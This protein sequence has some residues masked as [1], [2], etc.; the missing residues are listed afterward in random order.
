MSSIGITDKRRPSRAQDPN[1]WFY[2]DAR[3]EFHP[4][5]FGEIFAVLG[6]NTQ[7]TKYAPLLQGT[8]CVHPQVVLEDG[9]V[10]WASE[11]GQDV[12]SVSDFRAHSRFLVLALSFLA[13]VGVLHIDVRLYPT[14][15]IARKQDDKIPYNQRVHWFTAWQA[16]LHTVRFLADISNYLVL[17]SPGLVDP[18]NASNSKAVFDYTKY[19]YWCPVVQ[20]SLNILPL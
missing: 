3:K 4:V 17:D 11:D 15:D 7:E 20:R 18:T 16:L 13:E 14:S 12:L 10:L 6:T 8:S 1:H 5:P 9:N 2:P 19:N